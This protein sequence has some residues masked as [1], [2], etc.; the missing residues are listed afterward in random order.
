MQWLKLR[1]ALLGIALGLLTWP[2]VVLGWPVALAA[3]LWFESD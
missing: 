3:W 1:N 2:V